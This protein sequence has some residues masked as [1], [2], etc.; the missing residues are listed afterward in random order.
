[1]ILKIPEPVDTQDSM[2]PNIVYTHDY[3][4]RPISFQYQ[5]P[6]IN[7]YTNTHKTFFSNLWGKIFGEN[8]EQDIYHLYIKKYSSIFSKYS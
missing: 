2:H 3:D 6:E 1:M 4:F 7:T 5:Y 8:T